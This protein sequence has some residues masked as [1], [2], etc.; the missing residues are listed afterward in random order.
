M[1]LQF[2]VACRPSLSN[3]AGGSPNVLLLVNQ[4]DK[5]ASAIDDAALLLTVSALQA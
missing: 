2:L 1:I 3:V 5:P 4:K